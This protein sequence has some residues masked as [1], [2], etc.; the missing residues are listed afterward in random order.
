MS[1]FLAG[2]RVAVV[3][4]GKSGLASIEALTRFTGATVSAW[5]AD[6]AKLAGA[7]RFPLDTA[8][9]DADSEELAAK[10]MAWRPDIIMPAPAIPEVGALFRAAAEENIPLWSEIELAWHLRKRDAE[11]H[12]A[13]WLMVTGTNGKTT[14]V[15]LAASILAAAGMG[16][17]PLGN[18]GNPAVVEV[19]TSAAKAF[20]LELSSFQLRTTHSMAPLAS[21]CL[22]IA[23]DHLEWH[24]SREAYWAAKA[25][26]Y[27]HVQQAAIYPV[28]DAD[29]Q[30]MVDNADVQ[31]GARA[32]GITHG[33]P[34][35][36]EIGVVDGLIVDRAFGPQRWEEAVP[37]VALADLAHLGPDGTELPPYMLDD[38]LAA[39][40]LTRALGV[41]SA[42]IREGL[43]GAHIGRHRIELVS[44]VR[45]V[46]YVDDSKATNAHAARAALAAQ[47]D[48]SVVWIVG[49]LPKG[50]EF[51]GLVHDV[52]AALRGVVVIGK[53]QAPW[54]AALD[55]EPVPTRFIAPDS[56]DPMR[57]AVRAAQQMAED[58]DTVL[59]A[60]ASASMDQF[61]SYAVRG[62]RF[63]EAVRE[64]Q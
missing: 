13:P 61:T 35:V 58:G 43:A 23:D 20:V 22:N 10:V 45:G 47:R 19:A 11:G 36:G 38:V 50:A 21:V 60:P 55:G 56:D 64:L 15:G 62:E 12:A 42:H 17:K 32:I 24:G 33:I 53:D 54:H 49:G 26:V 44:T 1:E 31:E 52:E 57:E 40:A 8:G 18:F 2:K 46:R 14:A 7:V 59:L 48:H 37:V 63:A 30:R 3:G 29:V 9:S 4:L 34:A 6:M 25:R 28:G 16:D 27:E 39:V 51:S 5:D 41:S